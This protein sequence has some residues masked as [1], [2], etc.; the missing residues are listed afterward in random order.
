MN[1]SIGANQSQI[2]DNLIYA[3]IRSI[4]KA[5]TED[6]P[7]QFHENY[8]ETNNYLAFYRS[9][10]INQNLRMLAVPAGADLHAFKR[11][12]WRG[13]ILIDHNSR[14]TFSICT[15]GT[16]RKIPLQT[17]RR[18]HYQ[19]SMLKILNGDLHG[20]YEQMKLFDTDP[21]D[22]ET[23]AQDFDSI[24]LG[25]IDPSEGYRHCIIV[26]RAVADELIEVKLVVL[27]PNFCTVNE[28][29]LSEYIKPDFSRLTATEATSETTQEDHD[30]A[31]KKLTSL[32]PGIKP[33]LR[34]EEKRA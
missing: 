13:R 9:D 34:E 5:I 8:M 30:A 2:D 18:P 21:F 27:D 15:E 31:T 22:A 3:A 10:R 4:E 7:N 17:R 32:K 19:Q 6:V 11:C 20:R 24:S 14:L 28:I 25:A 23:Y 26:Y 16:L 1:L 29:N 33:K 12:S